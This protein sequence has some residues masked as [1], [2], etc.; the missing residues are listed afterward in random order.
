MKVCFTCKIEK[1]ESEFGV[2]KAT[3]DGLY[4]SCYDC[5]AA[6]GREWEKKNRELSRQMDRTWRKANPDKVRQHKRNCVLRRD[7]GLTP[8]DYSAV[9]EFQKN[10]CPI[11]KNPLKTP[12]VDHSHRTGETRGLV[13]WHCNNALGKF[14]DDIELLK[15]AVE[16]LE[17]HPVRQALGSQR[18]GLPGRITTS[19]ARRCM[20]AR[21]NEETGIVPEGAYEVCYPR[22]DRGTQRIKKLRKPKALP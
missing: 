2:R 10:L 22:E 1:D 5:A 21:K 17:N 3:K 12:N 18:F 8:E 16:Y 15:A 9:L 7:Y 19:R 4:G 6:R 20:L 13:C 11:C 14:R